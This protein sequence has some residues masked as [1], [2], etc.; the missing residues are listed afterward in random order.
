MMDFSKFKVLT[1]DCYGTL[2]DWERGILS[3][4]QPWAQQNGISAGPDEL[5]SRY[6]EAES[7]AEKGAAFRLYPDIL[8]ATHA[9]IARAYGKSSA[10]TDEDA[11]AT[12]VGDWPIFPDTPDALRRL[13]KKFKL[14]V[15][16]NV[17]KPS[18]ARTHL[19]LGVTL[20]A[21]VTAEDV[22]AYKPDRRMFQ[23]AFE[24]VQEWSVGRTE[25]LHVAQSLYHDHVPAKAL[26][27]TT[28]WVDRRAGKG[29][30]ATTTPPSEVKPDLVVTSLRELAD[31]AGV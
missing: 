11:L 23:R 5:L 20:D 9:E 13:Q 30:G 24:V 16:S 1:F 21:V 26:G 6:G 8:R 12:S 28:V 19:K 3:V 18:F 22:G 4:L 2:I 17:D 29:G 14:V 27:L 7:L 15:V 31:T 25:I 10:K